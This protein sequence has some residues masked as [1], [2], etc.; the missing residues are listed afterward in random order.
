MG[1]KREHYEKWFK[2][3]RGPRDRDVEAFILSAADAYDAIQ[4]SGACSIEHLQRIVDVA[5]SERGLAWNCGSD[6]LGKLAERWT[7]AADAILKMTTSP[8]AHVR[9]SA[10]C[11]VERGT[12]DVI[13]DAVLKA[14]IADKSAKVRWK[15]ADTAEHFE[16]E[17]LLPQLIAALAAERNAK[18]K[19]SIER[20][21][22]MLRDGYT[23]TPM[24]SGELSL[25]IH[26]PIGSKGKFI[27]AEDLQTKGIEAIISEMRK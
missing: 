6:L 18:A 26:T 8:H 25:W 14:G 21:M 1:L 16:K 3:R 2:S 24:P 23:L 17:H 12:P 19:R 27:K 13:G 7:Q 11:C 5:S 22:L 9:F 10:M 15:A 4:V 20:S